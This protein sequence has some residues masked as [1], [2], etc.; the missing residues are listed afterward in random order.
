M[1]HRKSRGSSNRFSSWHKAAILSLVRNLLIY[2]SIKTS[3]V[4]AKRARSLA[5]KMISLAKRSDL[6]A[7]RLSY[8]VLGD[9]GLVKRLFEDIGPR[10][11]TQGG[12][13]RIIPLGFRRGDNAKLAVLELTQ[14][15]KKEEKKKKQGIGEAARA[16][17]LKAAQEQPAA[18]EKH[19]VKQEIV[20]KKPAKKFLT[21]IKNIFKKERDSL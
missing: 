17:G 15:K 12:Y 21:G 1:R 5:E 13:T 18:H 19:P 20:D 16:P 2:Q 6:S 7:K 4:N 10:F 9:H 11:K 3:L 8:K 14:I